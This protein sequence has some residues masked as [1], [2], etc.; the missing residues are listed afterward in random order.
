MDECMLVMVSLRNEDNTVVAEVSVIGGVASE[1]RRLSNCL[2][3]IT[4]KITLNLLV[5]SCVQIH[6]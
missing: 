2:V 4:H 3:N 1:L 6:R 5:N